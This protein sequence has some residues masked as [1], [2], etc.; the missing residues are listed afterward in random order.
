METTITQNPMEGNTVPF[1]DAGADAECVANRQVDMTQTTVVSTT[2][3]KLFSDVLGDMNTHSQEEALETMVELHRVAWKDTDGVPPNIPTDASTSYLSFDLLSKNSIINSMPSSLIKNDLVKNRLNFH[4]Y[5]RADIRFRVKVN[6][7]P[8]QQGALWI[9][10]DNFANSKYAGRTDAQ[11]SS[12]ACLSS[13]DGVLLNLEETTSADLIVPFTWVQDYFDLTTSS[14][15]NGN[16]LGSLRIVPFGTLQSAV[17]PDTINVVVMA[18]L[19]NVV[20]RVP[21]NQATLQIGTETPETGI[22]T[23][24]AGAVESVASGLA[25]V[26][27]VGAVAGAVGWWARAVKG[28]A[29]TFGFGIPSTVKESRFVTVM[30]GYGAQLGEGI[31]PAQTMGL[32][33]DNA[34]VNHSG[35]DEMNIRKLCSHPVLV[36]NKDIAVPTFNGTNVI[37]YNGIVRAF[38]DS[39]TYPSDANNDTVFGGRCHSVIAKFALWR[40]TVRYTF[41]MIKTKFVSGRLKVQFYPNGADEDNRDINK[42]YTKIWDVQSTSTFTFDVPFATGQAFKTVWN[43][44]DKDNMDLGRII[45]STFNE[46]VYPPSTVSDHVQILIYQSFP[47]IILSGPANRYQYAENNTI[48]PPA[49]EPATLQVGYEESFG[50]DFSLCKEVGGEV[51]TSLRTVMHK[52]TSQTDIGKQGPLSSTFFPL[53]M[54]NLHRGSIRILTHEEGVYPSFRFGEFS[55]RNLWFP[56]SLTTNQYVIPFYSHNPQLTY[57]EK[58]PNVVG[59]TENYAHSIGDDYNAWNLRGTQAFYGPKAS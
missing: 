37:W 7:T 46:F 8:F 25:A 32:I 42:L 6:A 53:G 23:K 28:V 17:S 47:D 50:N 45:V 9:F 48:W 1:G 18:C 16:S 51:V 13:F 5:M 27:G 34:V 38:P 2:G 56:S 19:E 24:I 49:D 55:E 54:Y 40:G 22:V 30:N 10:F 57:T 35:E 41:K 58:F 44:G 4:K 52:V 3:G 43:G 14:G 36:E 29:S 20:L 39:I 59:S 21:T 12:T 26:P 15:N 33:Q 11:V 31:L